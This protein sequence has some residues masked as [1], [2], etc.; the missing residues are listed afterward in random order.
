M[1]FYVYINPVDKATYWTE[2]ESEIPELAESVTFFE[3]DISEVYRLEILMDETGK[4]NFYLRPKES[5]FEERKKEFLK[6]LSENFTQNITEIYPIEKQLSDKNDFDVAYQTIKIENPILAEE[7]FADLL[8]V[9]NTKTLSKEEFDEKYKEYENFAEEIEK[10]R[11]YVKRYFC[12]LSARKKY[13]EYEQEFL[14]EKVSS[15]EDFIEKRD[16]FERRI[17]EILFKFKETY[18]SL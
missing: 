12:L 8:K 15:E 16:Y 13:K 5:I 10:M 3:E 9:Y 11:I 6:F 1:G 18:Y 2:N 17:M 4:V 14:N 7:I